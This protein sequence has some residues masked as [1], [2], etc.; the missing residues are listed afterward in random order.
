MMGVGNLFYMSLNLVFKY[1]LRFLHIYSQGKLVCNSFYL[2]SLC[3]LGTCKI[4][5]AMFLQ[6]LFCTIIGVVL[7]LSLF[8]SLVEF[9]PKIV[10][11]SAFLVVI[12]LMTTSI[13]LKAILF[14]LFIW[15]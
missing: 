6:F 8:K 11:P 13:S 10:W 4:N 9:Y 14:K 3:G 1:F 2:E 12:F 7:S 15:S 5:L